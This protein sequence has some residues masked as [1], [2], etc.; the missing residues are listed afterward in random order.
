MEQPIDTYPPG[1]E[2]AP[3]RAGQG[4]AEQGK[5]VKGRKVRH[6]VFKGLVVLYSLLLL[7]AL[8][9]L[10]LAIV[11]YWLP[12]AALLSIMDDL[13]ASELAHRMHGIGLGAIAWPI[14]IGT[15]VQLR[16]PEQRLAPLLMAVAVPVAIDLVDL[17]TGTFTLGGTAPFLFPLLLIVLLHPRA[18]ELVRFRRPDGLMAGLT[19]VAAGPWLVFA[20]GQL[21]LQRLA[22]PGDPHA[23]SGHWG[24]MASVA[25][26]AVLWGLIG[27]SDRPGWR[28][29]AWVAGLA[30][31][32]YG[33]QSLLFPAVAS[34]AA[35]PWAIAAVVWAVV[36]LV[37]AE[38]RA[39]SEAMDPD[40]TAA[41]HG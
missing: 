6:L 30:A 28:L 2:E 16:R 40:G 15:A 33:L 20:Y 12:D 35:A 19:A 1:G 38:R 22:I 29:V 13:E 9:T 31:A 5:R 39:R 23:E 41:Q 11:L 32:V 25:L 4:V 3:G 34:A 36:Y 18:R 21:R 24:L 37:A 17:A 27:A 10:F 26:L 7:V 14:F 8:N